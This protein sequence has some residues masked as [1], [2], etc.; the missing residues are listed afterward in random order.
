METT[1]KFIRSVKVY[2]KETDWS[3]YRWDRIDKTKFVWP[4]RMMLHPIEGLEEIKY[5]GKGSLAISNLLLL[6]LFVV[7][8]VT[9]SQTG[10]IFNTNDAGNFNIF[11]TFLKSDAL[12][13]LWCISNWLICTLLDGEG[14][15]REI[16]IA[17]WYAMTPQILFSILGVLASNFMVRQESAFLSVLYLFGVV[18]SVILLLSG[19][20]V[21]HQYTFRK[22]LLSTLIS[23]FIMAMIVFIMILFLSLFQQ[24]V[25]FLQTVAQELLSRV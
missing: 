3:K 16:W 12:V 4:F 21:V 11:L 9:Y 19:I 23:L 17:S 5:E 25:M 10:F 14:T 2:C 1:R 24:L 7:S 6:L 22:T 13:I 18:W 20:L 15:F 8:I